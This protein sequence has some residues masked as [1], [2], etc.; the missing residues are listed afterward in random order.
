MTGIVRSGVS[1][2]G[3]SLYGAV[4]VVAQA[5]NCVAVVATAALIVKTAGSFVQLLS[6]LLATEQKTEQKLERQPKQPQGNV[7]ANNLCNA[8]RMF[9]AKDLAMIAGG[10]L[11]LGFLATKGLQRFA[12]GMSANANRLARFASMQFHPINFGDLRFLLKRTPNK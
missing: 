1:L 9:T 7:L 6:Q 2:V 4:G 5:P 3:N 8:Y 11:V 10:A 12:P